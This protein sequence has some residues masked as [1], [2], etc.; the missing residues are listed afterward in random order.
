MESYHFKSNWHQCFFQ[1]G[2]WHHASTTALTNLNCSDTNT[3]K[4]TYPESWVIHYNSQDQADSQN[5]SFYPSVTPSSLPFLCREIS[6]TTSP[7]W[8]CSKV[9]SS[10]LSATSNREPK[11]ALLAQEGTSLLQQLV[12]TDVC[13]KHQ[14]TQNAS[15]AH[16]RKLGFAD[17]EDD[18][19]NLKAFS[20]SLWREI[21]FLGLHYLFSAEES[22]GLKTGWL[23]LV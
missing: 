19:I 1:T 2:K 4:N 13:C 14:G 18:S 15:G 9:T 20:A 22:L 17:V 21:S 11:P 7:S 8:E 16:W 10:F 6:S 12:Y 5:Y 3:V 23:I